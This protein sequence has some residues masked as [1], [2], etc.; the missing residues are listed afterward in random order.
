MTMTKGKTTVN[1]HRAGSGTYALLQS[2]LSFTD[3][4]NHWAQSDI[5]SLASKRI[6]KGITASEFA[7]NQSV[8]R[9]EFVSLIVRSL[10]LRSD[11]SSLSFKDVT[12]SDWYAGAVHAAVQA[13]IVQG[14]DNGT[15]TP[16]AKITREE[17]A[18]MMGRALVAVTGKDLGTGTAKD[19]SQFTDEKAIHEWAQASVRQVI[20]IGMMKG[21][22]NNTFEPGEHATRAQAVVALKRMLEYLGFINK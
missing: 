11:S 3:I 15:F 18:V 2:S 14:N 9:A 19:L 21:M 10:G 5:E 7:P 17:M 20:A 6:V 22:T 12:E 4:M 8:T 16:Q 1:M 13:G